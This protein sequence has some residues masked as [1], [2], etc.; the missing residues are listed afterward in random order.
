MD[1]NIKLRSEILEYSLNIEDAIN[2]L[3][4]MYLGIYDNS[5]TTRLFGNKPGI[6]F[7]NKIDLLL[8]LNILSKEENFDFELLM[9]FRNKFLHDIDCNSFGKV[10]G[11]FDNGLKN[12]FKLFLANG[13]SLENEESCLSAFRNLYLKNIKVLLAKTEL[14][15]AKIQHKA[16]IIQA[17]NQQVTFQI[18]L[19]FDLINDLF[20][21]FGEMDLEDVNVQKSIEPIYKVCK[22][23]ADK[24]SSDEQFISFKEQQQQFFNDSDRQKEFWNIVRLDDTK[25]KIDKFRNG[26]Q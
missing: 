14:R 17:Y 13:A 25:T 2:N 4:L 23:H 7:K 26:D 10:I 20:D 16:E 19:F 9:I 18:D 11:Q 24:Y 3:L 12:K 1:I 5:D 22:K 6:T 21:T 15:K 8:D